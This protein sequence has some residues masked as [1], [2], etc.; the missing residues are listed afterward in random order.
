MVSI[1]ATKYFHENQHS[2]VN[3]RNEGVA[4]PESH[5]LSSHR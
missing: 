2:S 5:G 4:P 1:L 3:D